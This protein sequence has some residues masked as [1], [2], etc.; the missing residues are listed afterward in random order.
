M[1]SRSTDR[2]LPMPHRLRAALAAAALVAGARRRLGVGRDAVGLRAADGQRLLGRGLALPRRHGQRPCDGS[3]RQGGARADHG[4]DRP[5]GLGLRRRARRRSSPDDRRHQG[6]LRLSLS[7]PVA[8][9]PPIGGGESITN[10]E[11]EPLSAPVMIARGSI[12][13]ACW[14]DAMET[15]PWMVGSFAATGLTRSRSP[16][17]PAMTNVPYKKRRRLGESNGGGGK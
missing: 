9:A 2:D 16:P 7:R 6:A 17:L 3:R 4:R 15:L 8:F 12:M 11:E 1:S 13:Q 5:G 10:V 14:I